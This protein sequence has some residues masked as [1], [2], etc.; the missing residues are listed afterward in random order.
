[1]RKVL[2]IAA[3]AALAIA[4]IA[5]TAASGQV[6]SKFSVVAVARHEHVV[7]NTDVIGGVLKPVGGGG[8][9]GRFKI[10]ETPLSGGREREHAITF[11]RGEG[12]IKFKGVE[13]AGDNRLQIIG[14]TG[15]WNGASGKVLTRGLSETRELLTYTVVQ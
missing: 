2:L 4:G 1:M 9:I 8:V 13:G 6:V 14:G 10:K 11:F 3:V 15:V 5:A 12:L 7:G